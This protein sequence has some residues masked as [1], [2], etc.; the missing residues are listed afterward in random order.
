[1]GKKKKA[2]EETT[3]ETE[4]PTMVA[5]GF[6]P[7]E[8]TPPSA[9]EQAEQRRIGCIQMAIA[10]FQRTTGMVDDVTDEKLVRRATAFEDYLVAPWGYVKEVVAVDEEF[11]R[12]VSKQQER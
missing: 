11:E 5:V 8:T 1:M 9:E 6:N 2:K 12:L 10:S 4:G 3:V 7:F